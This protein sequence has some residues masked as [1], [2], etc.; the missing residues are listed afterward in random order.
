M[1][2]SSFTQPTQ[3]ATVAAPLEWIDGEISSILAMEKTSA[4]GK[5]RERAKD[6]DG[7]CDASPRSNPHR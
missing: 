3:Y 5:D 2:S 6:Y 7:E 1:H 4:A